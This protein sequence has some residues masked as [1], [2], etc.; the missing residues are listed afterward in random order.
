[1]EYREVICDWREAADLAG[2]LELYEKPD[3]EGYDWT[4]CR[5]VLG[6]TD[7]ALSYWGA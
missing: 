1:M 7:V 2:C 4:V 5:H 3:D 6:K